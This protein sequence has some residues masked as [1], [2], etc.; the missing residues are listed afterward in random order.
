MAG[1]DGCDVAE[2][3][4]VADHGLAQAGPAAFDVGVEALGDGSSGLLIRG[5]GHALMV[6]LPGQV[7]LPAVPS[8]WRNRRSVMRRWVIR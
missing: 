1:Q 4:A 3:S 2:L 6:A 7:A 8:A 5:V